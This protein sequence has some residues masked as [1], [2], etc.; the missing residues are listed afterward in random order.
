MPGSFHGNYIQWNPCKLT[1]MSGGSNKLPF[2]RHVFNIKVVVGNESMELQ[3]QVL[4]L[5]HAYSSLSLNCCLNGICYSHSHMK[6]SSLLKLLGCYIM[7]A[8]LSPCDLY[9]LLLYLG[10]RN[11]WTLCHVLHPQSHPTQHTSL[12]G[13]DSVAYH[14]LFWAAA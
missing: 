2:E 12:T 8:F 9:S 5:L 14:S 11:C 10:C 4:K 6:P 3:G 1:A 13:Q 7:F